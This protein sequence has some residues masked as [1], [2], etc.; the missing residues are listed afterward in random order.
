MKSPWDM[1]ASI[2]LRVALTM[3]FSM[4]WLKEAVDFHQERG[5]SRWQSRD[6]DFIGEIQGR[7]AEKAICRPGANTGA[8]QQVQSLNLEAPEQNV[9]DLSSEITHVQL[10]LAPN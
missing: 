1:Y 3:Y 2:A 8:L 5:R 4:H 10:T 6:W 9:Y 7:P